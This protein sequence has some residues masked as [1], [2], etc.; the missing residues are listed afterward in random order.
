MLA[1]SGILKFSA[2]N[3]TLTIGVFLEHKTQVF[4]YS[5]DIRPLRLTSELVDLRGVYANWILS[6]SDRAEPKSKE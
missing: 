6:H 5:E 4:A 2:K 1:L 3:I